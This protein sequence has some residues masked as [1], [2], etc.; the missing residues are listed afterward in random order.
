[1]SWTSWAVFVAAL[2]AALSNIIYL[3]RNPDGFKWWLRFFISLAVIY[4]GF[5]YLLYGLGM[6][7]LSAQGPVLMR[8]A[9]FVLLLLLAAE[10][11]ADWRRK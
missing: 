3:V 7:C 2:F 11:I 4:V 1:M 6:V 9:I 10:A 8:P 5:L